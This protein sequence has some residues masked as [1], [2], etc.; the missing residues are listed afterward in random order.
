MIKKVLVPT[1]RFPPA[2][3]VGLRRIIKICKYLRDLDCEITFVTTQNK[4]AVNNYSKDIKQSNFII[5]MIPS[6]VIP[7]LIKIKTTIFEKVI[8]RLIYYITLPLY[9]VDYAFLWGIILIP[10]TIFRIRKYKIKNIYV[11]G[12]P[13]STMWHMAVIK[14]YFCKNIVLICEWRDLWTDD[15]E[16]EYLPPKFITRKIQIFMENFILNNANYVITVTDTLKL[17]LVRRGRNDCLKIENGYDYEDYVNKFVLIEDNNKIIKIVYTGNIVDTRAEGLYIFLNLLNKLQS[18]GLQISFKIYGELSFKVK[19]H[20]SICYDELLK[21]KIVQLKGIVSPEKAIKEI[22]TADICLVLVQREH[23]E[24][25]TSKFFEYCA[26]KKPMLAIGPEGDLKNKFDKNNIGEFLT[27]DEPEASQEKK[28]RDLF[29]RYK[30]YNDQDFMDIITQN[31]FK[32]LAKKVFRIL[33]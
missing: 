3:G 33:E 12:P 11:S 20:I 31:N 9:F 24:A 5:K 8:G 6:L 21:K 13:F 1:L 26:A 22:M 23:P 16:R 27:L 15:Y 19:Q 4:Y 18:N 25:L 7:Y 32:Y 14:K 29:T 10:Y 28:C 30:N 17:Y 2:G